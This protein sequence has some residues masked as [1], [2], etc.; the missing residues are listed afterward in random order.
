MLDH[1]SQI[2]IIFD[3]LMHISKSTSLMKVIS[4]IV[5]QNKTTANNIEN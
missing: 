2:F 3:K 1:K 4:T 5:D